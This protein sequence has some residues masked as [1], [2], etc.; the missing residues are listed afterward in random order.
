MLSLFSSKAT[1][2]SRPSTCI[3]SRSFVDM[4]KEGF[5]PNRSHLETG[6]T[7]F[8]VDPQA[9]ETLMKLHADELEVLRWVPADASLRVELE[10]RIKEINQI[11][12]EET[13]PLKIAKRI[14]FEG[15]L[16]EYIDAVRKE[17]D[18]IQDMR[19]WAVKPWEGK[20]PLREILEIEG[21]PKEAEKI[22]TYLENVNQDDV[23]KQY[24]SG[25]FWQFDTKEAFEGR[26]N[27]WWEENKAKFEKK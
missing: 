23:E 2:L 25:P 27:K 4:K 20:R 3:K 17:I 8:E 21:D 24:K 11:C 19:D 5:L 22:Y 13:D 12:I 18:L 1:R 10:K 16:E 15:P 26:V 9:R 14:P 7:G 6:V